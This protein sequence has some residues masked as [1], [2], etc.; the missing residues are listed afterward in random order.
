MLFGKAWQREAGLS[1]E[2]LRNGNLLRIFDFLPGFYG[3]G[4]LIALLATAR[5]IRACC[6]GGHKA[7]Q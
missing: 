6:Q 5:I 1:D 3:A 4:A 2:Q 7:G